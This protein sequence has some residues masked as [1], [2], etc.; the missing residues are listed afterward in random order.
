[1]SAPHGTPAKPPPATSRTSCANGCAVSVRAAWKRPPSTVRQTS[2]PTAACIAATASSKVS[3][4]RTGSRQENSSRSGTVLAH[5]PARSV[6]T[7]SGYGKLLGAHELVRDI[8]VQRPLVLGQRGMHGQV[9][10]DRRAAV[11]ALRRVRGHAGDHAL[12][13]ERPALGAHRLEPRRL[14]DQA[15]RVL[16]VALELGEAAL[17]AVLLGGDAMQHDLASRWGGCES[18]D[19]GDD[20]GLHVEAAAAVDAAVLD[21]ARE[22]VVRPLLGADLDDVHVTAERE[23]RAGGSGSGAGEREAPE[24]VARG[25]GSRPV[26]VAAHRREVVLAQ[27]RAQPERLAAF[28]EQLEHRLLVAGE[29]RDADGRRQVVDER[30]GAVRVPDPRRRARPSARGGEAEPSART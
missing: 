24:L 9:R 18:M 29:R 20:A 28:G 26:R 11:Q 13:G 8:G 1:M 4:T 30:Q 17:A 10:V 5:S 6:P 27:L 22:G 14:G 15:R 12:D 2:G 19:G 16:A 25:L 23:P 3:A 21:G 7:T